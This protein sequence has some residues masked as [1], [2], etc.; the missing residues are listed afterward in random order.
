MLKAAVIGVG[1][2]GNFHVQ[3]YAAIEGVQL[4]G[5]VDSDPDR[6]SQIAAAVGAP[7]YTDHRQILDQADLVSIV[8]P[9]DGHYPIARDC[10][11]AGLHVL[12]EKPMTR[13]V[14]EAEHLIQLARQ[15]RRV[16][17]VGHLERFN[18][19]ILA[20]RDELLDPMFIESHRIA[21]FQP[22]GTDVS[23]VLDLMI[24]DIDIILSIVKS[25]IIA[26]RP[27]GL[28]VLTENVDIAN[29]RIEFANGCIASVTASRVSRVSMRKVRVFQPDAYI[30]IDYT[31]NNILICRRVAD[32]SAPS[33]RYRITEE[34]RQFQK[35][36]TLM[37]EIRAFIDAIRNGV[38]PVV[39]GEDGKRALEVA[40]QISHVLAEPGLGQGFGV[41]EETVA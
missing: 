5:V 33:G 17:Q 19:G 35:A 29:A 38:P 8:V 7:A 21:Q 12:V 9:P 39:S 15:H 37:M 27:M 1:Y 2:L 32:P 41:W 40:L 23:V 34:G 14:E 10:L 22:R 3:K 25:D 11:E 20:L 24:H 30:S 31:E 26:I 18:P 16:L 6:A 13:T 4:V 28:P 36:D